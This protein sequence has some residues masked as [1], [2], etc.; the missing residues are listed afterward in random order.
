MSHKDAPPLSDEQRRF[1]A[2]WR[3]LVPDLGFGRSKTG[4]Y[5]ASL[6]QKGWALWRLAKEDVGHD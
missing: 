6:A 1:E 4:D 2:A 3:A 5:F